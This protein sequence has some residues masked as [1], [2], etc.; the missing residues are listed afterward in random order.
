MNAQEAKEKGFTHHAEMYGVPIFY[1]EDTAEVEAK[2]ILL[3]W[4]LDFLIW[5]EVNIGVNEFGF[6]IKIKDEL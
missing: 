5:I 2:N 3:G 6:P 1:N 4:W